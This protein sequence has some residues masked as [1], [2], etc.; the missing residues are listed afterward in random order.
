[1]DNYMV[2]IAA[3]IAFFA[4]SFLSGCWY[5]RWKSGTKKEKDYDIMLR[6][7]RRFERDDE[8]RQLRQR[9]TDEISSYKQNEQKSI[10]MR[11]LYAMRIEREKE[12]KTILFVLSLSLPLMILYI[13][14]SCLINYSGNVLY[15]ILGGSAVFFVFVLYALYR[16][17][18]WLQCYKTVCIMEDIIK[19]LGDGIPS[20]K[21]EALNLSDM[22]E[23]VNTLKPAKKEHSISGLI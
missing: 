12:N 22:N 19:D 16:M 3:G 23:L 5:G 21:Q 13:L 8:Y 15:I 6:Q 2:T 11:K 1:M 7:F 18:K 4:V 14:I 20:K 10:A 17:R 9:L